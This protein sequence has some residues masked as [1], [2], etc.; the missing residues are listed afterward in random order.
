MRLKKLFRLFTA[1]LLCATTFTAC[2]DDNDEPS[3]LSTDF[4][5]AT[6]EI[7]ALKSGGEYSLI[8]NSAKQPTLTPDASW[9][10][11]K[12]LT[13]SG[14]KNQIWTATVSVAAND[15]NNDR[16]ANITVTEGSNKGNVVVSQTA[17][18]GLV[19][20]S[21]NIPETVATDGGDYNI[22]VLSNNDCSV[23][24]SASWISV[25]EA[26]RSAMTEKKFAV[27]IKSNHSDARQGTIT[28]SAGELSLNIN[29]NQ[30]GESSTMSKT[31][32]DIAK[33]I[34]VGWNIGNTLEAING[35]TPSETAWG[36]PKITESL[37][38]SIKAAGINAVRL[39]VAWD[40][41]IE[42]RTTYKI[43][44]SWLNR[45][46]EVVNWCIENDL[47][48]I[49]NIHWDG[50]W[51]EENCT[52]DKKAENLK[53]QKALWTQIAT[54]LGNYDEHLLFAGANEPA[55]DSETGMSV[56]LEYEQAFIDAVRATGGRNYKR[57]LIVQ[58]PTA[59]IDK[60]EKYMTKLPTDVVSDRMMVEV[61]YY[62]PWQFCGMTKDE[63]WG[64]MF[65]FWG[66]NN[67]VSNSNRNATYQE[68]DYMI[69]E[70]EKMKKQF[71]D[72]GIP[73]ILGEY[74]AIVDHSKDLSD[75]TEIAAHKQSRYDFNMIA[76]R[77]AKNH[78]MVPFIWDTGE[79]MS[80]ANGT[81]TSDVIIPAIVEG[82]AA[83]VYPY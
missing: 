35:T 11:I 19:L 21:S 82:A 68:E 47:Y 61:H 57:T 18:D 4:K 50:G 1:V 78:G 60:T 55:V 28:I 58:G 75:A 29:I 74:G 59:D 71:V 37:I 51:L 33:A 53:E 24:T 56:L 72:K 46:D 43:K 10:T 36:N 66:K 25:T 62:T 52:E 73:V 83:G 27:S 23:A 80:R 39:P 22:V 30:S 8:V 63:S 64:K 79:G 76:T 5:V 42:D 34:N 77:E 17:A 13:C 45:V 54:K 70:F 44:D 65:Y 69:A 6:T 2:G 12:S 20:S 26:G 67:H 16:T 41:Y 31:A 32:I 38:A 7:K 40:G 9:V 3:N 14:S 48:V 49:V 81:V 15:S